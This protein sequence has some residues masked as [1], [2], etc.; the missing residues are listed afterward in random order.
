VS[1]ATLYRIFPGGREVLFDA[2]REQRIQRFLE[3]LDVHVAGAEDLDTL[4]AAVVSHAIVQLRAD[5]QLQQMMASAPG[6]VASGLGIDS[7][8]RI[9]RLAT[10]VLGPRLS[11]F[12]DEARSAELAEWVS[13]VVV[14]YYLAPSSLVDLGDP[15][16]A[17]AFVRRFVT[18]AFTVPTH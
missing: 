12:I 9:I 6:A 16:A 5:T 7:M 8:P 10:A 1:R 3:E 15:K 2:M 14:S 13:R 17:L 4:V 18:P 11:R